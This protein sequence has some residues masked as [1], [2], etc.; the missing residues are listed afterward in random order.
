MPDGKKIGIE[1]TEATTEERQKELKEF[2]L[3]K[4]KYQFLYGGNSDD[5]LS[6]NSGLVGSGIEEV[7]KKV[8]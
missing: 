8:F 1:I 3:Q 4:K 7:E 6:V 2:A 5:E